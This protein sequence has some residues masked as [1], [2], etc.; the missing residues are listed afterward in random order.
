MAFPQPSAPTLTP[1]RNENAEAP[2]TNRPDPIAD[3]PFAVPSAGFDHRFLREGFDQGLTRLEKL[4]YFV[5][6]A[7]SNQRRSQLLLR[8][9]FGELLAIRFPST[10]WKRL[11]NELVART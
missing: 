10:N 1:L 7:V 9:A 2:T 6:V 5:L 4:L 3:V 11:A 8:S